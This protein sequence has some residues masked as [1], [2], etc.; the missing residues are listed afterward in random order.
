MQCGV[1][2]VL[3]KCEGVLCFVAWCGVVWCGRWFV[4]VRVLQGG[5]DDVCSKKALF[6]V[7]SVV[8]VVVVLPPAAVVVV[9]DAVAV[10]AVIRINRNDPVVEEQCPRLARR[11]RVKVR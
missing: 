6:F 3:L 4:G 9:V 5:F 10:V 1:E 8:L 7:L 11:V 2:F